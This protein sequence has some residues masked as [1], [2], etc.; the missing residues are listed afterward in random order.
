MRTEGLRTGRWKKQD[1]KQTKEE[2]GGWVQLAGTIYGVCNSLC[3][4]CNTIRLLS[5]GGCGASAA[6]HVH[7]IT[8]LRF[9]CVDWTEL[10]QISC[11]SRAVV[12]SALNL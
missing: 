1:R 11:Q 8:L 5:Q 3:S 9:E 12:D 10:A 7:S 6:C 2:T 4:S